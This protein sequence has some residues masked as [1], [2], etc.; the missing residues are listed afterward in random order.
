MVEFPLLLGR[1]QYWIDS[2]YTRNGK[3]VISVIALSLMISLD[4]NNNN[5][6]YVACLGITFVALSH[7]STKFISLNLAA[8]RKTPQVLQAQTENDYEITIRNLTGKPLSDLFV[9]DT[10]ILKHPEHISDNERSKA[11]ANELIEIDT[12]TKKVCWKTSKNQCTVKSV[13]TIPPYSQINI[14]LTVN[15]IHRGLIFYNQLLILRPDAFGLCFTRKKI[16]SKHAVIVTPRSAPNIK[17]EKRTI[18]DEQ[19]LDHQFSSQNDGI[20]EFSGLKPYEIGDNL[21]RVNWRKF[22]RTKNL[23]IK[24]FDDNNENRYL[25]IID[26][27]RQNVLNEAIDESLSICLS[28]IN[29]MTKSIDI[30]LDVLHADGIYKHGVHY[31]HSSRV[32]LFLSLL[33]PSETENFSN[34]FNA[35][36]DRCDFT[37]NVIIVMS[38]N[39]QKRKEFIR[40]LTDRKHSTAI[41]IVR[42][43][44]A[45]LPAGLLDKAMISELRLTK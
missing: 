20:G 5:S 7:I 37:D 15:P 13:P 44:K 26:N 30:P 42:N 3:L 29:T 41:S 24:K 11:L 18:N 22:S 14:R 33:P 17:L 23:V 1:A 12:D 38:G 19:F 35:L 2:H 36:I 43:K 28:V 9:Q 34:L 25:L 31:N 16:Q 8:N 45:I 39:D 21:R 4:A 32:G 10:F 6:Y 40:K 27:C